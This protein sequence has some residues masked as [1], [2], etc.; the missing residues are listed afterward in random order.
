MVL[1]TS[2]ANPLDRDHWTTGD[3]GK[4]KVIAIDV[5]DSGPSSLVLAAYA[6]VEDRTSAVLDLTGPEHWRCGGGFRTHPSATA[7]SG[8]NRNLPHFIS[9]GS[10]DAKVHF[11][12]P[13]GSYTA[14][15]RIPAANASLSAAASLG[16]GT[17]PDAQTGLE[18]R[19]PGC[20]RVADT[21]VQQ[22]AL[23]TSYL[24]GIQVLVSRLGKPDLKTIAQRAQV[25]VSRANQST[26]PKVIRANYDAAITS[27]RTLADAA[28]AE[29]PDPPAELME[30]IDN[31]I[32]LLA[33]TG[34][35]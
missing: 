31:A 25:D 33:Q 6:D 10:L 8:D 17:P 30:A 3:F 34:L 12:L 27:L 28:R 20:I 21:A 29:F 4:G 11:F 18:R 26:N 1:S 13:A 5:T 22:K 19:D 24:N 9:A 7:I 35:H 16:Q 14:T 32:A 15:V 2:C 23:T